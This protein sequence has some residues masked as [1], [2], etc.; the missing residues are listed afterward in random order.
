MKRILL[1]VILLLAV[2]V[3]RAQLPSE[4]R[5]TELPQQRMH[6]APGQY[7]GITYL[8]GDRYAVVDDK[9]PGGGIVFFDI[10]LRD[11]GTVRT[12]RVRRTVP[13]E[14]R[15]SPVTGLDNEGV[16]YAEGRLYVS[17]ESDQSIREYDLEGKPTGRSFTVPE[18]MAVSAI[19]GNSGFEALTYNAATGKF[20]TTTELPLTIDGED[21]RFHRLQRFGAGLQADGRWLYRSDE[22]QVAAAVAA[23]AWA[24]VFGISALAALDDGRLIVM[25]RELYVP[26]ARPRAI[27]DQT[28]SRV[29][30]YVVAPSAAATDSD[31][32]LPK[33]LFC[34]FETR[35]S[36]TAAGIDVA[37][38]NFEGMCLGPRLPDGR[39]TLV[40]ISDSQGGMASLAT[41]I[42]RRRITGDFLKVILL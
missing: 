8:S 19:V 21:S 20:W 24:Y 11:D 26:A 27:L 22:P 25:E 1:V 37:L 3:C 15:T 30:L 12:G 34:E 16:A 36:L 35:L 40:L 14:T 42:G 39:H 31:D 5:A 7:S 32:I 41:S 18:D 28:F 10:P 6:V 13:E 9:L 29:K 33:Q 4:L 38:A 2:S 17:A 23:S